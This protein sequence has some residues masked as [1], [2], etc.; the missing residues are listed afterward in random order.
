VW[1]GHEVGNF[2]GPKAYVYT[3][4]HLNR[5]TAAAPHI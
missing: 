2:A 1:Q 4:G 5:A 3:G